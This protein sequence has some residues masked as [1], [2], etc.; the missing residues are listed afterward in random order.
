MAA[1]QASPQGGS[2]LRAQSTAA[3]RPGAGVQRQLFTPDPWRQ[4]QPVTAADLDPV[5]NRSQGMAGPIFSVRRT[6]RRPP[7]IKQRMESVAKLAGDKQLQ[8]TSTPLTWLQRYLNVT[9]VLGLSE[10]DQFLNLGPVWVKVCKLGTAAE[11][12][13]ASWSARAMEECP[14][15]AS[16]ERSFIDTFC[17]DEVLAV[18]QQLTTE[19]QPSKSTNA[20]WFLSL[21]TRWRHILRW[22]P[23]QEPMYIN[24]L[25]QY[26]RLNFTDPRMLERL[27]RE[28][29]ASTVPA[30]RELAQQ[31]D[32]LNLKIHGANAATRSRARRANRTAPRTGQDPVPVI[33]RIHEEEDDEDLRP[34][35]ED[36]SSSSFDSDEEELIE[37]FMEEGVYDSGRRPT[38]RA[39][40]MDD[41][42]R[43]RA[44]KARDIPKAILAIEDVLRRMLYGQ[45]HEGDVKKQVCPFFATKVTG[46]NRARCQHRHI[47]RKSRH[48]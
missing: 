39:I 41:A 10:E 19:R 8:D 31:V 5:V 4:A 15:I 14:D 11:D 35:S 18:V 43:V 9:K 7:S 46:C 25:Q 45:E 33:A 13:R 22:S 28:P 26:V 37:Y 32:R 38:V 12:L 20:A 42:L 1:Q 47:P 21:V 48:C 3:H 23:S 27:D 24:W 36:A 34:E 6:T 30:L 2:Q 44:I 17:Q 29:S 40:F 16:L